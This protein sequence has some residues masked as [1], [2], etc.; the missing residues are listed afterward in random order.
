MTHYPDG[1]SL[2]SRDDGPCY[3]VGADDP[4]GLLAALEYCEHGYSLRLGD[5]ATEGPC[6][7]CAEEYR[8]SVLE[9]ELFAA[10][11]ADPEG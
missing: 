6:P 10:R 2:R 8:I 5:M 4:T 1:G 9:A 3:D 7:S 11:S